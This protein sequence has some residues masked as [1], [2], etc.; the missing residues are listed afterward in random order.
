MRQEVV[1]NLEVLENK[2]EGIETSL[3]TFYENKDIANAS[4]ELVA[5]GL[6]AT[7]DV[8]DY[9]M[10]TCEWFRNSSCISLPR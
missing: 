6:N 10:K 7:E 1:T 2:V 4:V 5:A 8:I 9:Y 3:M